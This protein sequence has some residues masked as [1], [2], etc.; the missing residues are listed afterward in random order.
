VLQL[1]TTPWRRTSTHSL[2]SALDGGEWSASCSGS[3]TPRE[4]ASGIHWIGGWVG[5]RAVLDAMLKRKIPSPRRES[6]P[7]TPIVQPVAQCYTDW[8]IM[9][10]NYQQDQPIIEALLLHESVKLS[11]ENWFDFSQGA[12]VDSLL[13]M[14]SFT[15]CH[16]FT[17]DTAALVGHVC[18]HVKPRIKLK[19]S[20]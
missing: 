16:T 10:L 11:K 9:A 17:L 5:P 18:K 15:F 8:T 20:T 6:N 3:F 1:S 13:C 14:F 2:T 12:V 19:T 7:R 4:R